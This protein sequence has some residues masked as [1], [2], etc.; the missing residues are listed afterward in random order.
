MFASGEGQSEN[1]RHS[2]GQ[3]LEL[4]LNVIVASR[5][6]VNFRCVGAVAGTANGIVVV[7]DRDPRAYLSAIADWVRASRSSVGDRRF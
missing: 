4:T 3:N 7:A 1:Y 2:M 6:S 5:S